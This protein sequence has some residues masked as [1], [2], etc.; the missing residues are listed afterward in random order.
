MGD[1]ETRGY[2]TLHMG[3]DDASITDV[4]RMKTF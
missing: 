4:T 1:A 2:G 3:Y